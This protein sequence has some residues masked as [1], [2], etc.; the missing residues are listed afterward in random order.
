MFMNDSTSRVVVPTSSWSSYSY[1]LN[2]KEDY[3]GK[4]TF[5]FGNAGTFDLD[6]IS[7]IRIGDAVLSDV[8]PVFPNNATVCMSGNRLNIKSETTQQMEIYNLDGSMLISTPVNAG[9]NSITM[10]R[11]GI[12]I[13]RLRNQNGI[14]TKKVIVGCNK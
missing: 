4:I 14:L 7:L 5:G 6:S 1:T 12:F 10:N 8:R 2:L 3:S 11:T 9:E 13:V